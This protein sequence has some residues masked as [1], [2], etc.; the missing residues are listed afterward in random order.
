MLITQMNLWEGM[1]TLWVIWIRA[2]LIHLTILVL[3]QGR[4]KEQLLLHITV[5][6]AYSVIPL[7]NLFNTLLETVLTLSN[8]SPKTFWRWQEIAIRDC[9]TSFQFPII[10]QPRLR[11]VVLSLKCLLSLT[12]KIF[13][14]L[15]ILI[16]ATEVKIVV[17]RVNCNDSYCCSSY[18]ICLHY[19]V[20][21]IA[22]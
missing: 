3:I 6:L 13:R 2:I 14:L 10:L 18:L 5:L 4:I 9:I 8:L 12:V 15:R 20:L 1:I 7:I 17:W 21:L 11:L 22:F 16:R 19:S